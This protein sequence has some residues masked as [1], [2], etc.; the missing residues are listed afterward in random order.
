VHFPVGLPGRGAGE[1]LA[2]AERDQLAD[3]RVGGAADQGQAGLG[4]LVAMEGVEAVA[5]GQEVGDG[6][7]AGTG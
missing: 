2:V 5:L 4:A 7:L 3:D 1:A 6:A